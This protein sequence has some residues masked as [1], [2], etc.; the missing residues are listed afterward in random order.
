MAKGLWQPPRLRVGQDLEEERRATWLELFYDLVFVVA[1]AE[2]AH[3]LHGEVSLLGFVSFVALFVPIW[4]CW[5]GATFYA[6]RFDTDDLGHRLL[7]LLQMA[8]I[9]ALAVNVHHGLEESSVG[10]ALCYA[11]VRSILIIQYLVAGYHLPPAR[12]LTTWYTRGFGISVTLWLV[13]VFVPVPWRF[14]LWALGLIIDLCTPLTAGKLATQLP[15]SI[16][17]IPERLGLFTIIVLGE[18]VAAVVRGVGE[19]KWDT[20]STAS[21]LLG[22]TVAF[23][24]WWMYFNSVDGSPL[25]TI[26]RGRIR[27]AMTWLYAHL[28]LAIGLAATGVGVEHIVSI[29]AEK[30]LSGADRLLLCG[31]VALC[32]STLALIHFITCTLGTT[33]RRKILSAYRIGGAAFVLILAAAGDALPPVVL[34]A[35]VAAACAVQVVLDML[36]T[37][38]SKTST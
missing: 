38:Q 25:R 31:G 14:G 13:S 10:F 28:P 35:L 34:M 26:R 3:K 15:P 24:L 19:Q 33:R 17:H 7:T 11:A 4:L 30:A 1:I 21:A 36:S 27:T 16:S 9:A 32:L 12:P 8:L 2:V 22:L 23:S 20:S 5:L 6:T 18:S 37:P 29:E